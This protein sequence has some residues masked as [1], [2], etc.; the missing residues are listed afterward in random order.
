MEDLV[1]MTNDGRL[2]IIDIVQKKLK[3][4]AILQKKLKMKK[5]SGSH[6]SK[7]EKVSLNDYFVN[8]T[9]KKKKEIV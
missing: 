8:N 6:P 5:Q 9:N 7:N 1:L 3:E 4:K 2:F